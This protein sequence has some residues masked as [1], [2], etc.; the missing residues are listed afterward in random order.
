MTYFECPNPDCGEERE[1][2]VELPKYVY[3]L[4]DPCEHCGF[5]ITGNAYLDLYSD[6]L[7]D[8]ESSAIDR[9]MDLLG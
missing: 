9:A 6:L 2:E 1:V 3:G 5:E 8:G 7:V 4:D